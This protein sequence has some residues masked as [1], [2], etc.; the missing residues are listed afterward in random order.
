MQRQTHNKVAAACIWLVYECNGIFR[1]CVCFAVPL[2]CNW[3]FSIG[4]LSP[5]KAALF[6]QGFHWCTKYVTMRYIQNRQEKNDALTINSLHVWEF[7]IQCNAILFNST[8]VKREKIHS[9]S[10]L[11][12]ARVKSPSTFIWCWANDQWDPLAVHLVSLN[13]SHQH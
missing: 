1:L 8:A 3:L 2:N 5:I 13:S 10:L 9:Q 7:A 12:W 6:F 4:I 11:I